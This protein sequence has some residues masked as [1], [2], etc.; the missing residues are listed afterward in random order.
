MMN[1]FVTENGV[2]LGQHKVYEKSN[3]IIA[4]PKLIEL[5]DISGC[6]VT[7]NAMGCQKETVQK[8]LDKNA[9]Y[10]QAVE[11]NQGPIGASVR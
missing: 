3:E 2:S 4:M 5:L 6:L 9:Y 10:L 11:G 7:I 8:I 1:A